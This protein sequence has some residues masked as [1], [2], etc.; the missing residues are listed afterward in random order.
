MGSSLIYYTA[1]K[2]CMI[3]L[4]DGLCVYEIFLM[5]VISELI[6]FHIPVYTPVINL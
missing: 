2:I 3:Q 6:I 1:D 4:P 5:K